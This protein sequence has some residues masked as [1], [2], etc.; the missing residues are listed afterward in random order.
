MNSPSARSKTINEHN[1]LREKN[2]MVL[3]EE[4]RR[5]MGSLLK[6]LCP[7]PETYDYLTLKDK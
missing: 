6:R 7:F 3:R 4:E 1:V 2:L 5:N